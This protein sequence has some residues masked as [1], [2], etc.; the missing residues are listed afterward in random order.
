M[1]DFVAIMSTAVRPWD[2]VHASHEDNSHRDY[3][4]K[5]VDQRDID[6]CLSCPKPECTNCKQY[7]CYRHGGIDGNC[8]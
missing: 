1:R 2:S 5:L 6:E 3:R 7:A 4:Q 8:L